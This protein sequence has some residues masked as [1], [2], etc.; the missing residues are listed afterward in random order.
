MITESIRSYLI[1]EFFRG[2]SVTALAD[3]Q[4]LVTSGLLDSVATLKLV[5]YLEEEFK[6][7]IDTADIANGQLDT[8]RSIE[9][10]ILDKRSELKSRE[11]SVR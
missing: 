9:S 2:E 10:L 5:L 1:R 3:D 6:I 11:V 4:A 8:L 7:T